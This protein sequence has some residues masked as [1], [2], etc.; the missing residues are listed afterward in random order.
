MTPHESGGPRKGRPG[1][2]TAPIIITRDADAEHLTLWAYAIPAHPLAPAEAHLRFTA[3]TMLRS[4]S[5]W[6]IRMIREHQS[7]CSWCER[8]DGSVAA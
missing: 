1:T 8:C 7:E 5:H 6:W 2:T 3:N 4:R